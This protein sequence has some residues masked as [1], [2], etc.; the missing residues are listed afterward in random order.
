MYRNLGIHIHA[1]A[2]FIRVLFVDLDVVALEVR[3]YVLRLDAEV[4]TGFRLAKRA[5]PSKALFQSNT[6]TVPE[7]IALTAG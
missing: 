4:G 6:D 5:W 1:D 7:S 3:L 2:T